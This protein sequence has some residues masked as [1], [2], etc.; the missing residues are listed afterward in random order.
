[1]YYD[2]YY[3]T[4]FLVHIIPVLATGNSFCWFPC[5]YD[6]PPPPS[7]WLFFSLHFL[8]SGTQKVYFLPQPWH[9][10][11]SQGAFPP[12][13]EE[14]EVCMLWINNIQNVFNLDIVFFISSIGPFGLF[15]YFTFFF[16][17]DHIFLYILGQ[18]KYLCNSCFI[19]CIMKSSFYSGL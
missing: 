16:H 3:L 5:P 12:F 17:K 18:I 14:N 15:L 19:P 8:T 6:T 7:M 4:Y 13:I 10:P 11:F 2:Q 1:M 9:Q